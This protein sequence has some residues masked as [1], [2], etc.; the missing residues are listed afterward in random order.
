M[1]RRIQ[2]QSDHIG[3]LLR[4]L[5]IGADTP[6]PATGELNA[7][8]SENPPDDV[9]RHAQ[10]LGQ[11][12]SVPSRQALRRRLFQLRQDPAFQIRS[13]GRRLSGTRLIPKTL[14]PLFGKPLSPYT[15]GVG[16]D[17][18]LLGHFIVSHSVKTQQHDFRPFHKP[19]LFAPASGQLNQGAFLFGGASQSLCNSGHSDAS[20]VGHYIPRNI[21]HNIAKKCN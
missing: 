4:K 20:L 1:R 7:L 10:N 21:L 15:D 13:V 2:V 8:L 17:R 5:R 12:S 3:G 9:I 19:G 11:R 18:K 16:P 14:D 6:R